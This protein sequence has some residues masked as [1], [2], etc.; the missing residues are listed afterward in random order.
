MKFQIIGKN[1]YK[2]NPIKTILENRGVE[3]IDEFLNVGK[4]HTFSPKLLANI[5]EA[6]DILLKHLDE[7]STIFVQVDSDVDGF[8]SSAL[9]I[10][11]LYK[12]NPNIKIIFN[13][14]TNKIHGIYAH[15]VPEGVNLVIVPDA[16]SNNYEAHR[17]LYNRGIDVIVLDH[18]NCDKYSPYATVVNNQMCD[19]PNKDFSG[20][21]IAYKFC[22]VVDERL[23]VN[24]A[25]DYL[26]LVAVGNVADLMDTRSLE[27]RYYILEGLQNEK[28][29]NPLIKAIIER[30][31][32]SI[33]GKVNI[34]T[35]GW[36]VAPFINAVIR[37]GSQ[38]EKEN[39]FKAM[40]EN[41]N[42]T[43][44]YKKRGTT[45]AIDQ[46][47]PEAMARISANIKGRQDRA[48]DKGVALIEE[49]IAEKGL[50]KNKVL[51]IDTTD[52]LDDSLTGLVA[53]QL[54]QKYKRPT[55]LLKLKEQK[56][57]NFI[58]GGSARGYENGAI[59][60]FRQFVLDTKCFNMAEGHDNAFGIEVDINNI[61]KANEVMNDLLQDYDFDDIYY[62]D[63]VIP[64][65]ELTV[66]LIK[67]L[68]DLEDIWGK[69]VEKP[70]IAVT[71][72]VVSANEIELIGKNK[73]T[74]KFKIGDIEFIKFKSCEEEY[75]ALTQY[76]SIKMEVVGQCSVNEY[77][78]TKTY[79]VVI[80]D[81]NFTKSN[82]FNF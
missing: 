35:I 38:E 31:S 12:L 36:N 2:V 74:I 18:H 8:T 6:V 73:N 68:N 11:Y 30:Q 3:N 9:I 69:G 55:I 78:G 26:D 67:S 49:K 77:N 71:D 63:F 5:D 41:C 61:I 10:N 19:Y 53:M 75:E 28:I 4:Q 7:D 66:N 42:E 62:V 29:K 13:I 64:Y 45:E 32:Y 59:R 39:T 56:K 70:T 43:I 54:A 25:D 33:Q 21:G 81:Y 76:N 27:T 22:K 50:D 1:D 15:D 24:Y 79:Q 57:D 80:A 82:T 65:R 34:T 47:L 51:I 23:G 40:L 14:H 16:G 37:F 60:D 52:I 72:I 58:F 20:V 44:P 48:R 17:E 46:P